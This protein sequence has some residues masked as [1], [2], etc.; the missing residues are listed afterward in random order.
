V[1]YATALARLQRMLQYNVDPVL[2]SPEV[3]DL[4]QLARTTDPNGYVAYD[5]WAALTIY[6]VGTNWGLGL[7]GEVY[8]GAMVRVPT[9]NNGHIYLATV[10]GTSGANEPTWPT[11]SGTTV[12]DGTVTWQEAGRYLWTPTYNL[13]RA[14]GEGWLWKAAK[15]AAEYEVSV[16]SGKTFKRNQKYDMC[17][18]MAARYGGGGGGGIGS[19]R[20]GS[21][22]ATG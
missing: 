8:P 16:G 5:P 3:A 21:A 14:A 13:N 12:V 22:T 1:D 10:A 15:V 20:L 9:A 2:T 18:A 11:T 19:M 4:L 7:D 17:M 6:T